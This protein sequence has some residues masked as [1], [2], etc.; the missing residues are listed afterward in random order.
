MLSGKGILIAHS[1]RATLPQ[2]PSSTR[3]SG[4]TCMEP[5][6]CENLTIVLDMTG[7]VVARMPPAGLVARR[8]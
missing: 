4:I 7:V 2:R 6:L 1:D 3:S 5:R 8:G